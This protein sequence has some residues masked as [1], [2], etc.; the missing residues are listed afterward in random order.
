MKY[1]FRE[2]TEQEFG[3]FSESY[4]VTSFIQS[5]PMAHYQVEKGLEVKYY[6]VLEEDKIIAGGVFFI[7]KAMG[8]FK[9]ARCE[10]GPLMDYDNHALVK[11]FFDEL[12][13]AFQKERIMEVEIY[14]YFEVRSRDENGAITDE[15]DHQDRRAFLESLGFQHIGFSDG[16]IENGRQ[17]MFLK[18]IEGITTEK[19]MMS[20]LNQSARTILNKMKSIPIKVEDQTPENLDDFME[21]MELTAQRRGFKNRERNYY[22]SVLKHFKG[23]ARVLVSSLNLYQYQQ[24]LIE[25]KESLLKGKEA[26]GEPSNKK[27]KGKLN[28]IV[29]V[30]E[31]VDKKLRELD[32]FEIKDEF[33]PLAGA[34][35]YKYGNEITYLYSGAKDEYFAFNAPYALQQEILRWA[36][37]EKITRYNMY[38]TSGEFSGYHESG[39]HTF[40][41]GF[42]G[43]I[44]ELPGHMVLTTKP[45]VGG[46]FNSLKK[47]KNK[48]KKSPL[49]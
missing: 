35:F 32:K 46:V 2:L 7:R 48:L 18:E 6:G 21:I 11:F 34:L 26:I 17:F 29:F 9:A 4:P 5:V 20:S 39:V 42:N 1:T 38:Y 25:Q 43:R 22:A 10:M 24:Q 30:L 41:K 36:L 44:I 16:I 3:A 31:S 49:K 40:K 15:Y 12:K 8:P 27:Q 23:N 45:L 28:E 13:K 47:V 19:E 33:I 37:D 14:P